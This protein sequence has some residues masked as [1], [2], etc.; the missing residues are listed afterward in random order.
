MRFLEIYQ[1]FQLSRRLEL[2]GF[3]DLMSPSLLL[4]EELELL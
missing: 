4:K 1:K 2:D 3:L